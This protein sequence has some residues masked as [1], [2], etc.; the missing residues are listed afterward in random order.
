MSLGLMDKPKPDLLRLREIISVLFKYKF[1][2]IMTHAGF[3]TSFKVNVLRSSDFKSDLDNTAPERLRLVLE[4]LGTTFI[5]LGQVLSTRPDLVGKEVA[6]ELSKLQDEVPPFNFEDV[7]SVI[8]NE[9]E[10]PINEFFQDFEKT[11]IA[12][13]S[14]AQVHRA[15]LIDGTEVAVK[16][17]R[18]NLEEEIKKDTT[19]M[20][21]LA[22]QMDKRIKNVKYYNLPSIVDEF[23]RVI[24]NEMDFTQEARN[25]EK[26]RSMFEKDPQVYAP[27][28]YRKFS[29][30]QV[31][32][33]EF[34][35]GTKISEILES[36][37]EIDR[38]KIAE[39]GTESYFKMIFLNGFFHADP[40]PG[41]IF[42][43][44]NNVLCFVDFGMIGHLDHEFMDNLAELFIYT[45]NYDIKG[46]VNQMMYM[47]LIDDSVNIE[48]LRFDLLNLLDRYYGAQID[49]IGGLINAFSMP[50]ILIKHKIK[51]PKDF[52]LLGRVITMAE[53]IGRKLDPTF[54]GIHLTQPLI[55]KIIKKKLSPLNILEYQT[56]YLFEIEHL[57][58]DLPQ[59]MNRLVLRLENGKINMETDLKGLDKFSDR[60]ETMT[61]RISLAVLISSVI[62]GS[63][64]ILQTNKGM[65]MPTIG[66]S[67]VGLV[68]FLI[69]SIF[70]LVLTISIIRKGRL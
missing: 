63:S 10:G 7:K 23:E 67:S 15:W 64:L 55:K 4:E 42:V 3:K 66:F 27:K 53:D 18:L 58:K 65:P 9:L 29:T 32:T 41:N 54:N 56:Q 47:R 26:F 45:I 25:L 14:I 34:I 13:A 5:K 43:M 38:R 59:T 6:E 50:E 70:A 36:D 11:P 22:R 17:Q 37:I 35:H 8:E 40:H 2:N 39:I 1:G 30:S 61:N 28:V 62:I 68:I 12:S 51:L 44:E 33:M 24:E 21:Y 16:V 48:E 60:L 57:L 49:D 20:R 46:M 19:L 69:G 52:I 31:L